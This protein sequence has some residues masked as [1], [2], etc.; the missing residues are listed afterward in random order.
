MTADPSRNPSPQVDESLP[1]SGNKARIK[2]E[3][4]WMLGALS[5]GIVV[6]PALVY[7]VGTT[8]LGPY[9]AASAGKAHIGSFY[10][11]VFRD[12]AV[13]A[14]AAWSIVLGPLVVVTLLR[15]ILLPWSTIPTPSSSTPPTPDLAQVP[16]SPIRREPFIGS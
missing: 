2:R 8:L 11:D 9:D 4:W 10:G 12:L 16:T 5:A 1:P 13:P 14:L 3:L 15:L 6:L 7:W